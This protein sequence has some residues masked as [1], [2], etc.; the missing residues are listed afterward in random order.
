MV[1]SSG[2]SAELDPAVAFRDQILAAFLAD[3]TTILMQRDDPVAIVR[4]ETG[5][6]VVLIACPAGILPADLRTAF[7]A[8]FRRPGAGIVQVVAVS[9]DRKV[10]RAMKR[11]VPFW[12]FRT[13]F[14]C[15]HVDLDGRIKRVAGVRF[16]SLEQIVTNAP[17]APAIPETEFASLLAQG[18]E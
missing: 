5:Q 1:M 2:V 12:Q 9:G 14:G 18:R 4:L 16:G 17:S 15:H 3:R 7:D 13:R 6:E 8:V 10:R 11:A